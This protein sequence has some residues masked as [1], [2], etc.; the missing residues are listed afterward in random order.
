MSAKKLIILVIAVAALFVLVL[1]K[2][3][4]VRKDIANRDTAQEVEFELIKDLPESFISRVIAYKGSD[5]ANK[6]IISR[7]SEGVWMLDEKTG[8]KARKEAI[9]NLFSLLKGLKGEVRAQT[10]E[11]FS[12]FQIDD[13]S[14]LHL[15]LEQ[16]G[17]KAL[18]HLVVSFLQPGWN[19]NF[20]RLFDSQ[21]VVLVSRNIPAIFGLYGKNT[22]LDPYF[23]KAAEEPNKDVADK[24]PQKPVK[25]TVKKQP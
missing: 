22:K 20:I 24:T 15:I 21:K 17:G 19:K 5:E 18:K 16:E 25:P 6:V 23:L 2:K 11:V 8:I 12:D 4:V 3:A 9:D 1:V 14:G 13:Q 10:K 7:N